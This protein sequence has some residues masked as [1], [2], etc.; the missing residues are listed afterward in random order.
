M[1]EYLRDEVSCKVGIVLNVFIEL[2]SVSN[3]IFITKIPF[4]RLVDG[5]SWNA[6]ICGVDDVFP[7]STNHAKCIVHI[8]GSIGSMTNEHTLRDGLS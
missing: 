5:M 4:R 2:S 3:S 7:P 1:R 6:M 8:P